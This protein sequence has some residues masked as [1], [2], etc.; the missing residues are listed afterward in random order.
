M[1]SRQEPS[2]TDA[3]TALAIESAPSI[4]KTVGLFIVSPPLSYIYI[5]LLVISFLL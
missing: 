5:H 2:M 1:P 4:A 3:I